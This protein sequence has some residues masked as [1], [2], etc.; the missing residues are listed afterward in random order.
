MTE[1]K[2]IIIDRT[3]QKLIEVLSNMIDVKNLIIINRLGD[4]TILKR[5]T[6]IINEGYDLL[7]ELTKEI[8]K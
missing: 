5:Y 3:Q 8:N 7:Q 2:C 6:A 4:E 1:D